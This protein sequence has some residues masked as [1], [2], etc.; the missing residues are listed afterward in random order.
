MTAP[1][2]DPAHRAALA[3]N[4]R[5]Q[6]AFFRASLNSDGGFDCLDFARRPMQ[7]Q[8][9]ELHTT[10][11]MVHSYA[12]AHAWGAQ[13]CAPILDAGMNALWARHRD[14]S[15]GGYGWSIT[16]GGFADATKLAYGHV[17]VLLAASSALAVGHDLA[18]R[19]LAD[20]DAVI[21]RHFWDDAA[22]RLREE[23]HADWKP[24]STY[25]GMNANMH[26]A[27][28]FLAAYE[29]TGREKYLDRA[30]RILDFFV[31][32]MAARHDNRIPE[33]YTEGW[34]VD[35]NYQGNPMFRPAGTTPGH[36]LEFARLVLQHWDLNGRR[37]PSAL[38]RARALVETALAD[39]WLP[40]GGLAYTVNGQGQVLVDRR[41]W[42]PVTE[43]IGA[44]ATL[45]KLDPRPSDTVW[46]EKLWDFAQE[47]F[48]DHDQGGWFAEIATDGTPAQHQFIGKPDIYHALQAMLFP[49]CAGV[50]Q[51]VVGL[52][53]TPERSD[54]AWH[55]VQ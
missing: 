22:G 30:G 51:M 4:A 44:L 42:W 20:I 27:E 46:Y 10:T 45:M 17:F 29:A 25:R 50:S 48:V 37:A 15:H 34:E 36:A 7:D 8:P 28:A 18:Q 54:S 47:H 24:F 41:Y 21:D 19:Q 12:L 38:T 1:L 6:I 23:Y 31:G 39:A 33:H 14:T 53:K 49:L 43:A 11:R 13:E 52:S 3:Q 40:T 9:Q 26:G 2:E 35:S 5:A 16:A 55:V 32:Q